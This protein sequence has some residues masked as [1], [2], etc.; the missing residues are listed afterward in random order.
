[1]TEP[2]RGKGS[3]VSLSLQE[4]RQEGG[5]TQ[6]QTHPPGS[7]GWLSCWAQQ[8]LTCVLVGA[9]GKLGPRWRAGA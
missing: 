5:R 9:G 6:R 3:V 7:V 8:V 4:G 1:M 2:S